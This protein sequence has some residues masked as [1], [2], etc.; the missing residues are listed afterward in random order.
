V[1]VGPVDL[2]E[3]PCAVGQ[4]PGEVDPAEMRAIRVQDHE[5]QRVRGYPRV[6]AGQSRGRLERRLGPAVSQLPPEMRHL[7]VPMPTCQLVRT[8]E[9]LSGDRPGVQH[10]VHHRHGVV[11]A[12]LHHAQ[13]ER[14]LDARDAEVAGEPA[15]RHGAER[16]EHDA[17]P[18]LPPVP[19]GC[20]HL[21]PNGPGQTLDLVQRERAE[22]HRGR[23]GATGEQADPRRSASKVVQKVVTQTLFRRYGIGVVDTTGDVRQAALAN[24]AVPP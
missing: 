8:R 10:V 9:A 6:E 3:Q 7:D 11:P 1:D 22:A 12:H 13:C 21:R 14:V 23:A 18:A 5:L 16:A 4:A 20:Y 2:D 15:G 19:A 17:V 24:Q